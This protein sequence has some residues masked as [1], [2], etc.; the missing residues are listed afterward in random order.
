MGLLTFLIIFPLLTA[1]VLLVLPWV[2]VRRAC[3]L[4][5]ATVIACASLMLL[6]LHVGSRMVYFN[7]A[8]EPET[9]NRVFLF[10]EIALTLYLVYIGLR[11]KRYLVCVLALAQTALLVSFEL[12]AGPGVLVEH[13]LF[14]DRFSLIMALIAG[15]IGGLIVLYANGY[16][17]EFHKHYRKELIDRRRM[18]FPVVFIFLSAMFGIIFSNNL[19]WLYFFWEVTTVCSF[20]LISY[21]KTE[22]SWKNAFRALE[23]NLLGGVAFA[24]SLVYLYNTRGVIEL[25]KLMLAGKTG[26]MLPIALLCFAGMVKSAQF[27]FPAG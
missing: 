21:K 5:A 26:A 23:M 24:V 7:F 1:G 14:I 9:V 16:M 25:D 8:F 18:F 20:F 13:N 12:K 6:A 3:T 27:P 2:E 22:E 17:Q 10:C 19:L 11:F 4:L 15:V